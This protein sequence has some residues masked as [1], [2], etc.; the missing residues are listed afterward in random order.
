MR[1]PSIFAICVQCVRI[2]MDHKGVC[3]QALTEGLVQ[4]SSSLLDFVIFGPVK[5]VE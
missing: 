5:F 4:G 3:V 1:R 2:L